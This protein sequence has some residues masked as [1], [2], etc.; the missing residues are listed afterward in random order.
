MHKVLN[1]AQAM[2][3]T[4][5]KKPPYKISKM[6][7][8]AITLPYMGLGIFLIFSDLTMEILSPKF[9]RAFSLLLIMYGEF[10]LLRA[11]L[12]KQDENY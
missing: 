11:L 12:I 6:F 10:R 7:N 9:K 5:D 2:S 3:T 4:R 8:I 1:F